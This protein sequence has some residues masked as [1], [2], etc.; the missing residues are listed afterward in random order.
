MMESYDLELERL[1]DI[2][3]KEKAKSVII[4][5][6]D[7]LKLKAKEISEFISAKFGDKVRLIFWAGSCFGACD[8]P[9]QTAGLGADILVQ[10]GHSEWN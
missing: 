4:Q 1:A 3:N 7:G 9:Q 8:A 5:L 10:F 6:P 2:I